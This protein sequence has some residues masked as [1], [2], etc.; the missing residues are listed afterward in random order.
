LASLKSIE[1]ATGWK[2]RQDIY[3]IVM[4]QKSLFFGKPVFAFKV[5]A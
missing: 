2:L 5:F 1:K 4:G 3:F